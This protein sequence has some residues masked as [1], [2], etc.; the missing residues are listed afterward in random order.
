[1]SNCFNL[2]HLKNPIAILQQ[3][4]QCRSITPHEGGAQIFLARCLTALGFRV[5]HVPFGE[6]PNLYASNDAS[7][8]ASKSAQKARLRLLFAGHSDVVPPGELV[9]WQ[10]P[11]FSGQ[12]QEGRIFGRGAQDMKGA[13]ACFIAAIARCEGALPPVALAIT[14]DEEGPALE[15]TVKLL[16]HVASQGEEWDYALVGEPT[17]QTALGDVVKIGRRGSLNVILRVQGI[18]GHV[19]Y[20][21]RADNAAH[22]L[23]AHL[24]KLRALVLDQGSANF[25][26]SNLEITQ[27][28]AGGSASNVV[29]GIAE[30]RFNIRFN[31]LWSLDSLKKAI[32]QQLGGHTA[33]EAGSEAGPEAGPEIEWVAG[34]SESFVLDQPELAKL[35]QTSIKA[36]TGIEAKLDTGGGTSDARFIKNYCSVVEFG[37]C[38]DLMHKAN[39][40]VP[41]AELEAL[42]SI[43]YHLLQNV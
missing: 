30:A 37:L 35:V 15:G 3:L 19:A 5:Q 41:L 31:D 11:P 32:K 27:I 4:L 7:N 24:A 10:L 26:A 12:I 38:G 2:E 17:C 25:Q 39:E 29:P 43:Y 14:G 34:A 21:Q 18:A 36:V 22:R 1:M 28:S 20:P 16:A 40:S 9:H 6:V 42:T 13:I 33:L 8:V 23:I